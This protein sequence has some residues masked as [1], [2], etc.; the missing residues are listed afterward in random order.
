LADDPCTRR[1]YRHLTHSVTISSRA[2]WSFFCEISCWYIPTPKCCG[3]ICVPK[4][5]S[6]KTLNKMC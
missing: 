4:M 6:N 2:D 1:W 3:S 5:S